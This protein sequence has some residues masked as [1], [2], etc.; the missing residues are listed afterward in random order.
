MEELQQHM[1]LGLEQA[2]DT[3]LPQISL[4]RFFKKFVTEDLPSISKNTLRLAAHPK[5]GRICPS[6]VN[7]ETTLVIG[8]EGGFIDIEMG[9]LTKQGFLSCHIGPRI[10]RVETAVTFLIARLFG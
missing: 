2:R 1:V 4:H 6:G 5:A 8:P 9:T 3:T 7:A 10:L